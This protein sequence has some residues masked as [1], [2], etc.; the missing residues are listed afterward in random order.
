MREKR[1]GQT[2]YVIRLVK[3]PATSPSHLLRIPSRHEET[4]L[5]SGCSS[6]PHQQ[7]VGASS[8]SEVPILARR[9]SGFLTSSRAVAYSSNVRGHTEWN[10]ELNGLVACRAPLPDEERRK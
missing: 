1:Q 9:A 5:P 3:A 2:N 4:K 6:P 10:P 8:D 7:P